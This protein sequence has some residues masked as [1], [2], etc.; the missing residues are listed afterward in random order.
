MPNRPIIF[1]APMVQALLAGRKTQ[2]RRV[3]S[4]RNTRLDG[5]PW[6]KGIW[7]Q[8]DW[9]DYI[10]DPGPSPA[11]N[12]GPYLK[13]A[14]PHEGTRHRVYPLFWHGDRLWVKEAHAF[15]GSTDPG[16][17]VTRADYPEC[18][19]SHYENVPAADAIRWRP[20]IH[21]PRSASRLTLTVTQVRM[22]RLH[23]ITEADAIAEGM[24][25][26]RVLQNATSG[27][28]AEAQ[29]RLGWPQREYE[30]LWNALHGPGA[31]EANPHVIALTFTV[32]RKNIDG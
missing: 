3:L 26:Y 11:G 2:T 4:P 7:E 15:V 1:S 32:E 21:M 19:P 30:L 14:R 23:E 10:V 17:L 9:A 29:S 20:S 18:V 5:G 25:D 24:P 28:I 13:V 6:F 8:M 16:L 22:Q 12:P 31:W 27:D